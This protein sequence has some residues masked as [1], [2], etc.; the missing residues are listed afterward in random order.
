MT[1]RSISC[2]TQL[3]AGYLFEL[4]SSFVLM[5]T[6]ASASSEF[7][8]FLFSSKK[9]KIMQGGFAVRLV[10][11]DES[12]LPMG[13]FTQLEAP[14]KFFRNSPSKLVCFIESNFAGGIALH[15]K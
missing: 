5:T 7:G 3:Y 10:R 8:M 1:H 14:S 6:I 4:S 12:A 13:A 11:A 15:V 2:F 9:V